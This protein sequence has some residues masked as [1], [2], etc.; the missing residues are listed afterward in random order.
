MCRQQTRAV[1]NVAIPIFR[2]MPPTSATLHLRIACMRLI[3]LQVEHAESED[4]ALIP[5]YYPMLRNGR[6]SSALC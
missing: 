5:G 1:C 2:S 4:G 3:A 6:R